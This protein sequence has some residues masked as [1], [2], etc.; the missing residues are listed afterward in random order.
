MN[1]LT[2]TTREAST[3]AGRQQVQYRTALNEALAE[4][5]RRDPSVFI[6][7]EGIAERGGSYKVT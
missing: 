4:E 2:T 1:K 3:P 7:G 5:M 6:M